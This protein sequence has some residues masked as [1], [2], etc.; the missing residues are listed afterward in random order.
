[1]GYSYGYVFLNSTIASTPAGV[2]GV[3][4]VAMTSFY[5]GRPWQT[6]P[7]TVFIN[8]YE[9]ATV[10][11]AG[12]TTMGPN[13]SLYSEWGCYGPG[14]AVRTVMPVWVGANQPCLIADTTA[15]KYTITNI[16]SKNN[17]GSGFTYAANWNPSK[18]AVDTTVF[19][20]ELP[21][22]MTSFTVKSGNSSVK[23]DWKTATEINNYGFDIQR[24]LSVSKVQNSD[25]QKIGF[26]YGNGNSNSV[27]TYSFTDKNVSSS[28]NYSYRLKQ[29]D[30]NGISK[31]SQ[32]I[33][34]DINKPVEFNLNQ[35]YP[36]PFNPSTT[37]SYSI[38]VD[39]FVSLKVFDVL[40]KEQISL[41]N[42]VKPA[43]N[44]NVEFNA[45]KLCSG[46]YIY[47]LHSGNFVQTKKMI[48]IK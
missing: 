23:L 5:L 24:K 36:N 13:P 7:K 1:V 16:F 8:C 14:A 9:P 33:S 31:Y 6:S 12:W 11:A 21:V 19:E 27:K 45:A 29:I 42:E 40:G 10:N 30:K 46:F 3:D 38:P 4:S 37:I 22:E 28:G 48:L 20:I 25:W 41:V 34:V 15:A 18:I 2:K 35:N 47:Q 26:V 43:G 39:G 32:E 44:Y 17:S